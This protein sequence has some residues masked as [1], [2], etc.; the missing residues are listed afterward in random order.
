MSLKEIAR[1]I[2]KEVKDGKIQDNLYKSLFNKLAD[3]NIWS[4][5]DLES[6]IPNSSYLAA[7]IDT[8]MNLSKADD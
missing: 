8:S 1:Q 6:A 3:N 4:K 2:I 7:K 5:V